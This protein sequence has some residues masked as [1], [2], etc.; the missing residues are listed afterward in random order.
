MG[1][2]E[3][4]VGE[5]TVNHE[6]MEE[7]TEES[8]GEEGAPQDD[9]VASVSKASVS[10]ASASLIDSSSTITEQRPSGRAAGLVRPHAGRVRS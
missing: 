8:R 9:I 2:D 4:A 3:M 10:K 5:G 6:E 1:E 7:G